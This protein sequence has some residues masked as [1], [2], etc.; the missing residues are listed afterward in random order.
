[1][2]AAKQR[3]ARLAMEAWTAI[4]GDGLYPYAKLAS[5][6]GTALPIVKDLPEHFYRHRRRRQAA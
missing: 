4:A 5:A 2:R 3:L 1:M 6:D